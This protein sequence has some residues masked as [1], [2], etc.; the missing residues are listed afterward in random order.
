MKDDENYGKLF[1]L[2]RR[3]GYDDEDVD[4]DCKLTRALSETSKRRHR[5]SSSRSRRRSSRIDSDKDDDDEDLLPRSLQHLQLEARCR[6]RRR[7]AHSAG[8]RVNK[9]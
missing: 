3:L 9:A 4:M 6:G 7:T 5:D 2:L 8:N 1:E